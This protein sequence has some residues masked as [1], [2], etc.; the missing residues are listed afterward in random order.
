MITATV[1]GL[2][3]TSQL[4]G[5]CTTPSKSEPGAT[6]APPVSPP[7]EST[8]ARDQAREQ[9]AAKSAD[10]SSDKTL[11]DKTPEDKTLEDKTLEDKTPDDKTPEDKTPEDKTPDDTR[12]QGKLTINA[13]P[14]GKRFQG[15]WVVVDGHKHLISYRA[16]P[17]WRP[18]EGRAVQAWGEPYTPQG[19][20]IMAD[21]FRIRRLELADPKP[22]DT[23]IAILGR[24]DWVGEFVVH[25]WPKGSKLE[26]TT[27]PAFRT[28]SGDVYLLVNPGEQGE[29]T[30]RVRMHGHMA[31]YSAFAARPSMAHVWIADVSTVP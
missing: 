21:H 23:I 1:T 17:W 31:E 30:G 27:A 19:Q 29:S 8:V 2:G 11:E 26:G 14:G 28:D 12:L 25:T 18:F 20:A 24:Q 22:E 3:L 5:G 6:A 16:N 9:A 13:H 7:T 4:A 15:V 10:D